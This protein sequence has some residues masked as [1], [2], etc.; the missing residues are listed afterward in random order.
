MSGTSHQTEAHLLSL[1]PH[2]G[3]HLV[4]A[5]FSP[6]DGLFHALLRPPRGAKTDAAPAPDLFDRLALDLRHAKGAPAGGPWFVREHRVLARH[7][8][9]GRDYATLAAA[10]RLARVVTKNPVPEES[11]ASVDALLAQAFAAF[12]RPGAR[13]DL[14][15]F[16]SLYCLARDEGLPLKQ[17]WLPSLPPG[18]RTL[19]AAAL[20]RP[21]DSSDA[22]S[23][24][25]LARLTKRLEAY[26]VTEA[27]LT[28]G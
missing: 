26:L 7:A 28:I 15:F 22:P 23:T 8:G 9:I 21:S 12:A 25:D 10:S 2:T 16:K 3:D 24:Q 6:A 11:L 4:L 19:V 27:D 5:C 17:H 13:P 1:A 18:D 14:V 20:S